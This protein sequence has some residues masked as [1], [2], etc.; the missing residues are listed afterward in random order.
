MGRRIDE[1]I[2]RHREH[3]GSGSASATERRRELSDFGGVSASERR[4]EREI[5]EWVI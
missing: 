4:R 2:E 3:S 5:D 1:A